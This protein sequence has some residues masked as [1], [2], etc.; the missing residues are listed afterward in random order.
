MGADPRIGRQ[1]LNAGLGYG[2]S[3]FNKDLLAFER[4]AKRLGYDFPLLHEIERINEEALTAIEDKIRE[5]VWNLEDKTIVLLGLAFK[6]GTDDTRFAPA[7][8]LAR[9]LLE[10]GARVVGYDP[11]A[12][13]NAK[14]EVPELEVIDDVYDAVT[15]ASCLVVCTEW[16]EFSNL[17][18]P[19]VKSLMANPLVVDG[20]NL[21]DSDEMK[22]AGFYHY[23]T[24]RPPVL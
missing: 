24:G 9:R 2:G 19:R 16:D 20:R 10:G 5:A 21:F 11:K 14:S 18:L 23:P 3:C 6:P 8:E 13:A 4:L 7:L 22:A 17:D 15:G 12:A 1:F